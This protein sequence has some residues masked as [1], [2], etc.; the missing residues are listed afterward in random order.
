M[1]EIWKQAA[2]D[3]QLVDNL[4]EMQNELERP[5]Y[6]RREKS[7]KKKT[8][9]RFGYWFALSHRDPFHIDEGATIVHRNQV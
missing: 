4:N 1:R 8:P 3:R 6:R 7:T 2:I 5:T 9:K